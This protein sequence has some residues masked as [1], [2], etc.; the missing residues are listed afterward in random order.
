MPASPVTV[1][2][3]LFSLVLALMA[4][5][6]GLTKAD[7]L[8]TVQGYSQRY[9]VGGANVALERQFERDKDDL[10][11]LGIPLETIDSPD[12]PGDNTALRYLIPKKLYDLPADIE[13]SP[14][15]A[16]LLALAGAA[17]REGSLS[18]Q[19]RRAL[20]KLS[21][22]GVEASEPLVGYAPRIRIRE[23]AFDPLQ[24]ALGESVVTFPYVK[25][26]GSSPRQ[27]TVLPLAVV[28][29]D[30]RW[31]LY[32]HDLDLNETRTFLLSRIVGPVL[33][34]PKTPLPAA[35]TAGAAERALAEL[36]VL[37]RSNTAEILVQAAT[38]AAV[39]LSHRNAA[40][41]A[42]GRITLHFTDPAILAD[43]LAA[44]GPEV[45]VLRPDT[46]A[47]AVRE[48]LERVAADHEDG[49]SHD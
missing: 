9:S 35:P 34:K 13:F 44:F 15:E 8:S 14:Q 38:D 7:I 33:A 25:A 42:D 4:S 11:D 24:A 5:E 10:R 3:R 37:F 40:E 36:E 45:R 28:Q 46:L 19:S 47:D 6:N 29:F 21:S 49:V 17:W 23:A 48:R 16:S 31:H 18:D 30:G 39:R 43:E 22:R 2:E 12:R 1:E 20:M 32:A 26:G 27:R 41:S